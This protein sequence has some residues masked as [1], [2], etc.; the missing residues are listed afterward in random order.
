VKYITTLAV[1]WASFEADCLRSWPA[2]ARRQMRIAFYAGALS[3]LAHVNDGASVS[4]AFDELTLFLK[5]TAQ[6]LDRREGTND[7]V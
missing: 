1:E 2:A 5:Q 3:G 7:A 4:A 6:E